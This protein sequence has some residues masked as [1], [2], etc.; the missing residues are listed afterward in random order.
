MLE[1][2]PQ[3]AG[4][5]EQLRALVY[6]AYERRNHEMH[7]DVQA[8]PLVRLDGS[9]TEDLGAVVGDLEMVMRRVAVYAVA[10]AVRVAVAA[11]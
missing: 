8:T 4:R 6:C 5:E 1:N 7:A 9:A 3:F 10:D 11:P 2:D